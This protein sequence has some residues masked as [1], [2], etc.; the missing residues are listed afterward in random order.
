MPEYDQSTEIGGP[1]PPDAKEGW[2]TWARFV[3]FSI[4]IGG[5]LAAFAVMTA[6]THVRGATASARLKWQQQSNAPGTE[7]ATTS[8]AD[9]VGAPPTQP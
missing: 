8:N 7:A 6:P 2:S 1:T 4:V 3:S 9:T 5:G